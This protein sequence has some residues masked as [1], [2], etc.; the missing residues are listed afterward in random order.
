M[1]TAEELQV[2]HEA[3]NAPR[4]VRMAETL[5]ALEVVVIQSGLASNTN[6][7]TTEAALA[8]AAELGEL[9]YYYTCQAQDQ[10]AEEAPASVP[11]PRPAL[12]LVRGGR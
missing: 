1:A 10:R 3:E 5:R 6:A 8:V 12:K 4:R 2:R 11:P 7:N 9:L